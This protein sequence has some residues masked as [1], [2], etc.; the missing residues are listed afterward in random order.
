[1]KKANYVSQS[2]LDDKNIPEITVG[3]TVY[4]G[5]DPMYQVIGDQVVKVKKGVPYVKVVAEEV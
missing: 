5:V 1:M 2:T 3:E 4:K